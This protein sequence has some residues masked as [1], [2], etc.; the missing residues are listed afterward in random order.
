MPKRAQGCLVDWGPQERGSEMA[1]RARPVSVSIVGSCLA[2]RLLFGGVLG[3]V[4][5]VALGWALIGPSSAPWSA[6]AIALMLSL[7]ALRA[8]RLRVRVRA[9]H[10]ELVSWL[11]VERVPLAEIRHLG[12][13]RAASTLWGGLG[14]RLWVLDV[15]ARERRA[16]APSL[17]S[18][19]S[20]RRIIDRIIAEA[21]RQG[22]PVG[23]VDARRRAE[24]PG[25]PAA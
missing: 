13:A 10:L 7:G 14:V 8:A 4:A 11:W 25:N 23:F 3:L 1:A 22:T 17:S 24:S 15:A 12:T 16:F 9:S 21:D 20:I 18:R 5:A 19:A 6:A 2:Q